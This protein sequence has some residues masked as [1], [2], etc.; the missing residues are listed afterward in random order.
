MKFYACSSPEGSFQCKS[1]FLRQTDREREKK[2]R[3]L[4]LGFQSIYQTT[5]EIRCEGPRRVVGATNL[6][7]FWRTQCSLATEQ[8]QRWVHVRLAPAQE[9]WGEWMQVEMI[10]SILHICPKRC[11]FVNE[12]IAWVWNQGASDAAKECEKLYKGH[13]PEL[14]CSD[15]IP[16]PSRE[17]GL[18]EAQCR[19][20]LTKQR[21]RHA[22]SGFGCLEVACWPLISKF[23]GSH[24]AEAVRFLGRKNP[25][26]AFLR[27]GSKAVGPIS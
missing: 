4:D 15:G 8:S 10:N 16:L 24:P 26:H 11:L 20:E 27:R 25:Q 22:K 5:S 9:P 17:Y 1:Q 13:D 12:P 3:Q 7:A 14:E 2:D 19:S 18:T 6:T 23:A 21:L